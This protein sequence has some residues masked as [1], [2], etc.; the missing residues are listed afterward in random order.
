MPFEPPFKQGFNP[1]DIFFGLGT[2]T[3][4]KLKTYGHIISPDL[5]QQLLNIKRY[6]I[7]G[8]KKTRFTPSDNSEFV[9]GILEHEKYRKATDLSYPD[10]IRWRKKSKFGLYWYTRGESSAAVHFFLDQMNLKAVIKKKHGED[11]VDE[12]GGKHR[13]ITG[14]ELRWIYR[15]RHDP[16]VQKSV[17]FWRNGLPDYAPWDARFWQSPSDF[18]SWKYYWP[19]SAKPP[20]TIRAPN[21]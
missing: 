9:A 2:F 11:Y 7:N 12:L 5:D 16:Q 17:Q 1:G 3:I 21:P 6:L 10:F 19:R 20:I 13:S 4:C 18:Y 14:S 15:N 8:E